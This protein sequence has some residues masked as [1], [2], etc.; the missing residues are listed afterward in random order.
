MRIDDEGDIQA[1]TKA[2]QDLFPRARR[3]AWRILADLAS[4][5]DVAAETMA[6]AYAAWSRIGAS[7]TY[8]T[9]WV[10]RVATNLALD[11]VRRR[12]STAMESAAIVELRASADTDDEPDLVATRIVLVDA[13]RSLPSRQRESIALRY[14]AGMSQAETAQALGISVGSVAQH[15]H[16]G[17]ASLRSQLEDLAGKE[18]DIRKGRGMKIGS[19]QEALSLQGTDTVLDAHVTGVMNGGWGWTVDVGVPAVLVPSRR[20]W[21]PGDDASALV[22]Q[23]VSCTVTEVDLERERMVVVPFADAE[24]WRRIKLQHEQ[25]DDEEEQ[26]GRQLVANLES[27]AVLRGRV[28]GL[29]PF[30]AFVDIG[31]VH[32]LVHI[33]ELGQDVRHP[34][35]VLSVGQEMDVEV[36]D[37]NPEL[38]RVSLRPAA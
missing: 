8:R 33:S 4:A 13:M 11:A 30:G 29:V 15:V 23:V 10:L 16:R 6:R 24:L 32:G 9:G 17:L 22:G 36:L 37:T 18:P 5:E 26:R 12:A 21:R 2:F 3:V 31:G 1:F 38:Q 19:L 14:L 28:T 25:P 35:D 7:D 34:E 20:D 27:G